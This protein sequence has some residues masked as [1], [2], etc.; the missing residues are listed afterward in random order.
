MK[1][2]D[3]IQF[4]LTI[5]IPIGIAAC[6]LFWLKNLLE[7]IGT[8]ITGIWLNSDKSFRVLIY[9]VDSS[10]QGDVVW[11]SRDNQR[12]LGSSI[13]QNVRLNFFLFGKGRYICPFSHKEYKFRLRRLSRESLQLYMTDHEGK[14]VSNETWSLVA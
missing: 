5:L 10:F 1:A 6:V 2:H 13:L 7:D 3:L 12:I 8:K 9:D 14:L 11:A 4:F